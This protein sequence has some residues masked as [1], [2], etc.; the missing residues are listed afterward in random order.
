MATSQ[1]QHAIP[2][3][4]GL[5]DPEGL[6]GLIVDAFNRLP[7][8]NDRQ[9][10]LSAELHHR[11]QNTLA[12]VL[13]LARLT[14]RSVKTI[15]EFQVAFGERVQAMA[16][17]N[18][19]LLRGNIQAIN[20]RA[21]LEVEL[22][23]YSGG[24]GQVTLHCEP[25]EITADSALSLSLLIHELATNAAKYG[26]LSTPAGKLVVRAE[27]SPEGGT[28]S[29]LETSPGMVLHDYIA[30]SGSVL[31]RRLARDLGGKATLDFLPTGLEA[32]VTFKLD[33]SQH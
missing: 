13:A 1:T 26:G 23:P 5:A 31:I 25:L 14:A 15:D 33:D 12:I 16:R 27:G 24:S 20:V 18:A 30:G 32:V 10:M 6:G 9:D 21:A 28:L 17:T 2:P 7:T 19:L 4:G 8:P 3:V 29:W 11:V 22:E